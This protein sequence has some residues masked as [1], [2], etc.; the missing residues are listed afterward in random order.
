MRSVPSGSR[1]VRGAGIAGTAGSC[2]H[3][4]FP[5]STGGDVGAGVQTGLPVWWWVF[6]EGLGEAIL[7]LCRGRK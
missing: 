6:G 7:M 2:P 5:F 4:G 1:A 3:P